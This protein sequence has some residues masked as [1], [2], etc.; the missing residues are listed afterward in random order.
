MGMWIV[1]G[2]AGGSRGVCGCGAVV[3]AAGVGGEASEQDFCGEPG[4]D[5]GAVRGCDGGHWGCR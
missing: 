4:I 3:G 1:G 5:G 2:G